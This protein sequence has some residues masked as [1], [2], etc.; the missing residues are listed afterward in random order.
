MWGSEVAV[1][2]MGPLW[3]TMKISSEN[4]EF[5]HSAKVLEKYIQSFN[6]KI[7]DWTWEHQFF[8]TAVITAV[9][10][11]SPHLFKTTAGHLLVSQWQTVGVIKIRR[12]ELSWR[13]LHTTEP[14]SKTKKIKFHLSKPRLQARN[15][16]TNLRNPGRKQEDLELSTK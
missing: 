6:R 11:R 5:D 13:V 12:K 16:R 1:R 15:Y 14:T 10:P 8:E 7:D 2:F 3:F 9:F 4:C